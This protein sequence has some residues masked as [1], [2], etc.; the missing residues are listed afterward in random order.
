VGDLRE[1]LPHARF[2]ALVFLMRERGE[3]DAVGDRLVARSALDRLAADVRAHLEAHAE[4]DTGAFKD[5]S[6]QTRRTAIPLLEWLDA[7]GVT[8]RR[9]DVRVRA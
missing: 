1:R 4:L 5:L 8:K 9:G 3:V 2:D 6:G 7:A